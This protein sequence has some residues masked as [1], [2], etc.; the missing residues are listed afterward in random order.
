MEENRIYQG[1]CI[2]LFREVRDGSVDLVLADPPYNL[3]KD[4]GND[5][6]VWPSVEEWLEWSKLWLNESKRVLRDSGSLVVHG[7]HHYIGYVQCY[8]YEIGFF[9]GR[10]IIWH[11]ENSWS[12]YAR[13]PASTYEPILWFTKSKRYIFNEIREPYKS[14]ER[15][16]H[17]IIKN[18]KVWKPNPKGKLISDV[19]DIPTL[20]GRRFSKEKVN[21]PTQ[22]P[23]ALCDRIIELFS[24]PGGLVLVPFA[25][26]G[27]ECVSAKRRGRQFLG[28]E[29]NPKYVVLANRR[30][31]ESADLF[32]ELGAHAGVLEAGVEK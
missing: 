14:Q 5:S 18:G 19:W 16:R 9:Y 23:L 24:P 29:I 13:A 12:R 22:K 28:F 30:L 2:N 4:F 26:S 25:G 31:A 20:A 7:I 15:L 11:Y 8:L 17:K 3:G 10:T 6:D 1:D 32:C 21:H 27:S